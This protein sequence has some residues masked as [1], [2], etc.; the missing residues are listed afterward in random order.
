MP[1]TVITR[2]S[3]ENNFTLGIG[4]NLSNTWYKENTC[5]GINLVGDCEVIEISPLDRLY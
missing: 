2:G 1:Y 3:K 4:Y 5:E